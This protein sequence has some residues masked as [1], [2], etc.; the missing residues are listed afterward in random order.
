MVE[1]R[2]ELDQKKEEVKE[3][4]YHSSAQIRKVAQKTMSEVKDLA[5]LMN[6]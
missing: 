3:M 4:I 2:S 5:G 1:R 6:V